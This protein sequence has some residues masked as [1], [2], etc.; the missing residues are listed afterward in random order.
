MAFS[1]M[2]H[3]GKFDISS[4]FPY[5]NLRN[6]LKSGQKCASLI[7]FQKPKSFGALRE[8]RAA[9]LNGRFMHRNRWVSAAFRHQTRHFGTRR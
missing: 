2:Q 6:A 9:V 4:T 5:M 3:N 7:M 1:P 8:T